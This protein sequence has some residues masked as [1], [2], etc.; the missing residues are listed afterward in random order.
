MQDLP[1]KLEAAGRALIEAMGVSVGA[2]PV[3]VFTGTDDSTKTLPHALV[4]AQNGPEFPQGSGNF[5]LQLSVELRLSADDTS[6]AQQRTAAGIVLG[7]FM[8]DDLATELGAA[9]SDFGVF[10]ISNRLAGGSRIED[11][12]WVSELSM[13]VY[14][15][16][17]ALTA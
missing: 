8:S 2:A 3:L 1:Q 11:R 7:V 16:S 12:Q 6:V 15:C 5:T 9:T 17:Q 13:D 10:G 14:C 4:V